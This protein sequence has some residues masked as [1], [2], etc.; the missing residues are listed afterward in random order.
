MP[1][2][3]SEIAERTGHGASNNRFIERLH[4]WTRERLLLPIG[5]RS[6]GTGKR[7]VYAESAVHEALILDEM[8]K[9]SVSVEDQRKV[10]KVV[11]QRQQQTPGLWPQTSDLLLVIETYLGRSK[12]YFTGGKYTIHPDVDRT[13]VINLTRVF[14][15]IAA[16]L[17]QSETGV[18]PLAKDDH[19]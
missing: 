13:L 16:P 12:P 9:A 15:G 19:L 17:P 1:I 11:Q 4:Y 7:R 14:A 18:L 6:P 3:V 2:T 5:K 8:M 10:M